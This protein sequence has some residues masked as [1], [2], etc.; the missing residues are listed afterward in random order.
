[1]RRPPVDAQVQNV[2]PRRE[3]PQ[4]ALRWRRAER[5]KNAR[6]AATAEST[7]QRS[8]HEQCELR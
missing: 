4:A 2:R 1:M 8:R 7:V 3:P 5:K 6:V